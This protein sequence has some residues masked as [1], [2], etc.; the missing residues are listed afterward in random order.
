MLVV[1]S[2]FV[3]DLLLFL[4]I[5]ETVLLEVLLMCSLLEEV[6]LFLDEGGVEEC[7]LLCLLLDCSTGISCGRCA[8]GLRDN[9]CGMREEV[10]NVFRV[11]GGVC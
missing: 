1:L 4:E 11:R 10:G 8:H 9:E 7:L 3:T 6:F 5:E 2:A